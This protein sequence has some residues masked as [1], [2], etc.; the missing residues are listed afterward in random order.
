[1]PVIVTRQR[2]E[3]VMRG[4][5]GLALAAALAAVAPLRADDRAAALAVVAEA[6]KAHGGEDALARMRTVVRKSAGR[7]T[8][9]GKEII[10]AEEDTAQLPERW[11]RETEAQAGGQR[12]RVLVVVNGDKGWQSAGGAVTDLGAERLKELREEGHARR[13]A[14]LLPLTKDASLRLAPAPEAKV[15]GEPAPGVK[16]SAEGHADVL[17]YFDKKTHLLVKSERR[18]AEGGESVLREE[19]YSAYKEFDGVR[20]PTKV[21]RTAGGKPVSETTTAAYAFPRKVEE[22]TFA[23]P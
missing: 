2:Q 20:L 18:A 3:A 13:L 17:L 8:V 15:N 19:T 11:R 1:M 22:A 23:K 21:V 7:M 6:I 5:I 9:A 10:F 12:L 14:A 16:V 4:G